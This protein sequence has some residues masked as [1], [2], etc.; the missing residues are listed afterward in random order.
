[1]KN[2]IFVFFLI[3]HSTVFC[4]SSQGNKNNFRIY[5]APALTKTMLEESLAKR[6][7]TNQLGGF[8][9]EFYNSHI[10][11]RPLLG[12]LV[13]VEYGRKVTPKIEIGIGY[14]YT[15]KGQQSPNYYNFNG[16]FPS[17]ENYGGG[18]YEIYITTNEFLVRGDRKIFSFKNKLFSSIGVGLTLDVFNERVIQ[19]FIIE[20]KTGIKSLGCCSSHNAIYT[21]GNKW[22]RLKWNIRDKHFRF[23]FIIS[24]SYDLKIT[25]FLYLSLTPE[26]EYL[27]EIQSLEEFENFEVQGNI[28]LISL[29]SGLKI[30]F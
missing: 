11:N 12:Y 5:Y 24:N 18:S 29:Q 17:N 25:N 1:M 23:G 27:T 13:G 30:K 20:R 8:L 2:Y 9:K 21:L 3:F 26:F 22:D 4:Q 6:Y 7:E 19:T 14:R 15:L 10:P 16:S 28:W